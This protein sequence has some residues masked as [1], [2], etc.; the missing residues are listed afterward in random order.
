MSVCKLKL[1]CFALDLR[2]LVGVSGFVPVFETGSYVSP[3]GFEL[4]VRQRTEL[5]IFLPSPPE[6]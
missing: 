2:F 3:A 1:N 5:L 4:I 6:C